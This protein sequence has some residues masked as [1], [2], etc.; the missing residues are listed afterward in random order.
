MAPKPDSAPVDPEDLAVNVA[1]VNPEWQRVENRLVQ[2]KQV[3]DQ[4]RLDR[5]FRLQ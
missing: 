5:C 4:R 1:R 3:F 2:L